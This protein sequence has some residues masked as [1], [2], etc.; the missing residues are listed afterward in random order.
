LFNHPNVI[1]GVG[2]EDFETMERV[3]STSNA[4]GAVT[5]YMTAFRR[6]VF[7]DLHFKHWDSEKY[8]NLATMLYNNYRQALKIVE[9]NTLDIQHVLGLHNLDEAS[10]NTYIADER[11]FFATLGKESDG[12]LHAMAYVELLQELWSL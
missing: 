1:E 12:N 9:T 3:F 7:I 6:R 10:L 4:L 11:D 5:R 8:A 2:L